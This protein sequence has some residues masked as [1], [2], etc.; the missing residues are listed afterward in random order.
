V[1]ASNDF[2]IRCC[3]SVFSA[4][5][6]SVKPRPLSAFKS[7]KASAGRSSLKPVP[8]GFRSRLGTPLALRAA[9]AVLRPP[10][11]DT[12]LRSHRPMATTMTLRRFVAPCRFPSGTRPVP[13]ATR[14]HG[15]HPADAFG[16]ALFPGAAVRGAGKRSLPNVRYPTLAQRQYRPNSRNLPMA[17]KRRLCPDDLAQH[18]Q[19][20]G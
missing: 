16:A 1:S 19:T 7:L 11:N 10:R 14:G 9:R 13:A 8:T 4:F 15:K 12:S 6:S 5:L 3:V 20:P 2:A 18:S 17:V